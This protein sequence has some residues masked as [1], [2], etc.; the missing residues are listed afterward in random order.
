MRN[1]LFILMVLCIT[2]AGGSQAAVITWGTAMDLV[3][4]TDVVTHGILVEA[5]NTAGSE[6]LLNPL[7]NGVLFTGN[8]DVMTGDHSATDFYTSGSGDAYDILLSSLDFNTSPITVGGGLLIPGRDYLIQIWY[9]DE[10][11][12]Y[13]HRTMSYGDGNGNVSNPVNDQYVVGTFTADDINLPIVIS[14]AETN[15]P[16]IN[17]YQ[18]RDLTSGP[19]NLPA[20]NPDPAHGATFVSTDA[21]LIWSYSDSATSQKVYM[22]TESGNLTEIY[23]LPITSSGGS[24]DSPA[25][26]AVLWLDASDPNSLVLD[27]NN[28][29]SRWNDLS[30]NENYVSQSDPNNQPDYAVVDSSIY[31]PVV[32]FGDMVK[33][34][35]MLQPWMQFKDSA[36]NDLSLESIRM[37]FVVMRGAGFVLGGNSTYHFHRDRDIETSGEAILWDAEWTSENIRN[38]QSYLNGDEVDGTVTPLPAMG[39]VISIATTGPVTANT[40][41][42]DRTTRS[43][44]P[45]YAEILIYDR[46]LTEQERQDTETYLMDKWYGGKLL[47]EQVQP[48][49]SPMEFGTQYYWRVDMV[50]DG[51]ILTGSEWTF[52]TEPAPFDPNDYD[53]GFD[54]IVFIKRRPYTSDHYYTAMNNGTSSGVFQEE[55]GI[56]IYNIRTQQERSVVTAADFPSGSGT[57]IIGKFTL[58]FDATKLV[59]DYRNAGDEAFRI[60]E[61]NIDGTGLRQISTAPADEAEKVAR[62]GTTRVWCTDDLDPAYLPDG[63]IIFSSTRSEHVILC[64]TTFQASTLHRMDP[65]GQNI[66]ALTD[67]PVSEFCPVILEDG[68]VMYH[69]WEYIDKGHRTPKCIYTM[70]PDGTKPQELFSLSDSYYNTG[71]HTYPQEI[72]GNESKIVVVSASHYPQGNTLGPIQ[73][74]DLTKDN[75]TTEGL[76]RITPDVMMKSDQAGWY[77]SFDGFGPQH[78]DG[79]GGPLFTHPFPVSPNQFLVTKKFDWD[80]DWTTINGY[81]IYLIDTVGNQVAV[82][83]DP[84][85]TTSCW[86]PTPLVARKVP[87]QIYSFRHPA[88]QATNE[89]LCIVT[90]VYEGMEGVDPGEVKWL[91]INEVVPRF[92][93]SNRRWS[94]SVSSNSWKAALWSRVQWGLVP[95]EADGSAYFKVPADRNIMMQALDENYAELQRE[96]TYVNY[97]P[98]EIRSCMGCHEK[99]GRAAPPIAT[100]AA[101]ALTRAPSDLQAQPCDSIENGGD[102]RPEQVIHYPSDIQPIFNA[103]CASCHSG[104]APSGGLD[105]SATLTASYTV[106]Y[107]QLLSKELA[108]YAIPEFGSITPGKGG[109]ND[110]GDFMPPKSMGCYDS[111]MIQKLSDPGDAHLGRV[112]DNELMILRRWTD[113]NYQYYGTYYGRHESTHSADPDFRRRPTFEEAISPTA[114]AW[115]D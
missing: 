5:V 10:R 18:I 90:N 62:W 21:D 102:G 99:A 93:D 43:G 76:T 30:G 59:F 19:V 78:R 25:S 22:G 26:G 51:E 11:A 86:H 58:S 100:E 79:V 70:N 71:A 44:G 104:A 113:T 77:F 75:R 54:E 68:R 23:D 107:E 55:N 60:W 7:V 84:D 33:S 47:T 13:T 2:F 4:E 65:D 112:S 40:L 57:G 14:S 114:P 38:G 28:K 106:A 12:N 45:K 53:L 52:E 46:V 87:P 95:V 32:D 8:S 48:V 29:V 92:W 15:D 85:A 50:K 82:Y 94:P 64:G 41:A 20:F 98:G 89:A 115:H 80:A 36:G 73:I 17:A 3:D 34:T 108:G 6:I 67:S 66:E 16:H 35:D 103:K 105:L 111:A 69:R 49:P 81:A 97:R 31:G 91:R 63:D 101:I 42:K 83:H 56:Y 74:I 27:G 1:V 61:V 110:N 9:V 24:V 96:R 88:F 109:G 72:P 39:A 37:V